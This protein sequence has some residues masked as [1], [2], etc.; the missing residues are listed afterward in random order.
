LK[1]RTREE[2]SER[3]DEKLACGFG[4]S[5]TGFSALVFGLKKRTEK[6][7]GEKTDMESEMPERF[8]EK[9]ACG[10][11]VSRTGFSALAFRLRG[12]KKTEMET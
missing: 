4:A 10:L 11:G 7:D 1:G 2:T 9:L 6:K 8:D 5:R 12:V 3:F